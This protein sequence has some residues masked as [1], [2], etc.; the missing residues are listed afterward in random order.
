[1]GKQLRILLSGALAGDP[2]QGGATWAVLQYVLGLERLGHEVSVVQPVDEPR[3]ETEAY[4]AR[5]ISEFGVRAILLQRGR[6]CPF[7]PG[8]D[9]LINISGMLRD[10]ALES[11]PIRV[12]LDLDPVFNQLWHLQ[13]VDAGLDGHTHYATV[14]TR[15]PSC[16]LEWTSTLPPVVLECWPLGG[17][18]EHDAL[19]TVGNWRSYGPIEHAG[20]RYGQ[21]AHSLRRLLDLPARSGQ[22]FEL[23][24]DIDPGET[25][26][27]E[28]LAQHG[29]RLLDP[30]AVAGTPSTYS[31]FVRGSR[32]ELGIA[33]EGYVVSRCGWFSDRS[34][35]YLASGR[36]VLAQDT[37]FDD[38][39][40]TGAGLFVFDT[41]DGAVVSIEELR[42]D[43]GRHARAARAIAEEFLDSDRVLR[44]LLQEVGA[45]SPS[46][47]RRLHETSDEELGRLVGGVILRRRP[48]EY[49]STAP[50]LDVDVRFADGSTEGVLVKDL[51]RSAQTERARRAKPDFLIDP[52]RE[53]EVYR[54]L[55]AG[56]DLGTPRVHGAS[57]ERLWLA[58]EKVDGVELYQI[59]ELTIWQETLRWLA[60]MHDHFRGKRL[61]RW[62]IRYDAEFLMS[63]FARAREISDLEGF[64]GYDEAVGRLAS[65]PRT[66]LHGEFYASNVLVGGNRVCALDWEL[67]SSGPGVIDVAAITLGWADHERMLLAETYRSELSEPPSPA[68][69]ERDLDCARLHLA[70]QWLG[71][72]RDW[73]PPP[74]HS[75]DFRSEARMLA[76]RLA[77]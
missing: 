24:L 30:R 22:R 8:T 15:V 6:P 46:T 36:P 75:R 69:F 10:V 14:G 13:G 61:P 35:C 34:A 58:I 20:V 64:E 33:K 72:S 32:G 57:T 4:L 41:T 2:P 5:I 29:W 17:S 25:R 37:G 66:L 42:R 48:F 16:G 43:F 54:Q 77:L 76:E 62:L 44:R 27:I 67:A 60:R 47:R 45:V 18:I 53:I 39:L 55:L 70:V 74:E 63:W 23:A 40:P 21:K 38:R 65:L 19:T 71:W 3:P 31:D 49:R 26:D 9:V 7:V 12:Y 73:S 52:Q 50:I 56:A 68:E 1:V 51:S 59:G 28:A 11:I